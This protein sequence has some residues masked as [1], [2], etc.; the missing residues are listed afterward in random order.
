MD[1]YFNDFLADEDVGANPVL[2]IN[3]EVQSAAPTAD[4]LLHPYLQEDL[5]RCTPFLTDPK[6]S[7]LSGC[8][9][10]IC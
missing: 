1:E 10:R 8:F 6:V 4:N 2:T 5:T 7:R 9:I 3:Q